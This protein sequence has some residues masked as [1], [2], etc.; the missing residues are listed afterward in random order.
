MSIQKSATKKCVTTDSKISSDGG[1]ISGF[2]FFLLGVL[3]VCW[4]YR[5]VNKN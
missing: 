2:T 5:I 4:Q 1:V 3:K